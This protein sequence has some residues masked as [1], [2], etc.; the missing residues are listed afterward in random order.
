MTS[1]GA[2]TWA[3]PPDDPYGPV[4]RLA[5]AAI[6]LLGDATELQRLHQCAACR[7]LFLDHS[8]GAGRR[9]CSM[10]DCG[11]EA[12]KRRY[13]ARRRELMA[14]RAPRPAGGTPG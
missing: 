11:T 14:A 4:H 12:K 5:H 2:V 10:A 8:R 3:W 13:V 9:W 1:A 7:W 6:G